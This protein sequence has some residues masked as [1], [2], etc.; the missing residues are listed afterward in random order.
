MLISIN[1]R[2]DSVNASKLFI[3]AIFLKLL[4]IVDINVFL[5]NF[6]L[7]ISLFLCDHVF[8]GHHPLKHSFA[9]TRLLRPIGA[10]DLDIR[11]IILIGK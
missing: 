3:F 11:F 1:L 2:L 4:L 6:H 9:L 8:I 10:L 7:H 5:D